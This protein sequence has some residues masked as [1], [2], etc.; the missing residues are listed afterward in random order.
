M[1]NYGVLKGKAIEYKR[2]SDNDPHSELLMDVEG[3]KF[4]IAINVRSSRGPVEK[5]LIEYLIMQ[6][7]KHPA[8]ERARALPFGWNNLKDGKNDGAAIDYIR[9]NLFRATDMKPVT[10]LAP[11]PHND[12]FEFVEDLLQRA[13]LEDGAV[14]YAFG[15]KWGPENNKK[16]QYFGFLPGNGVHLIHMNQG[17][18]NDNNGTFCDGALVIDFPKSNTASA[19]FLKFQ[20]QKWHTNEDNGTVIVDAPAVPDVK[21][22]DYGTVDSWEVVAPD[23]PYHLAR[24]VAAMLNPRGDDPTREFVTVLNCSGNVLDMTGWQILDQHDKASK[25]SGKIAPGHATVFM[26]DG[27][28]AQLSNKGGTITLLDSRGLKVDGVAYTKSDAQIEGIPFVF[29]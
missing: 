15:E 17:D 6:D 9:S 25:I 18:A 1:N 11:G 28:G 24:I 14:V 29:R 4:R 13:I 3:K 8:V 12:L 27:T 20:N 21:I 10:H 23:S 16:D 5:R 7:I 2:D 26:L 19:L 22:P